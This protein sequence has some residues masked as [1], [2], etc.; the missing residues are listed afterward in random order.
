MSEVVS[1]E[2]SQEGVPQADED[3]ERGRRGED[4]RYRE[5]ASRP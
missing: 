5:L 4:H 1:L 3:P 2:T